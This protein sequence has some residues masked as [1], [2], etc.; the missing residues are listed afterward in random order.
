VFPAGSII[1]MMKGMQIQT[2][3]FPLINLQGTTTILLDAAKLI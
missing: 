1:R 2:F 3:P